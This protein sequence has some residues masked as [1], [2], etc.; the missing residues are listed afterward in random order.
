MSCTRCKETLEDDYIKMNA[1]YFALSADTR[2]LPAKFPRVH[3]GRQPI[4]LTEAR[5]LQ[6]CSEITFDLEN[7][8]EPLLLLR[9]S[10]TMPYILCSGERERCQM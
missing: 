9:R 3:E 7:H 4:A 5:V 1:L 10:R 2:M 6:L 8:K